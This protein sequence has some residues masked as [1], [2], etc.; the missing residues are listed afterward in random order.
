MLKTLISILPAAVG[1]DGG[2]HRSRRGRS[3]RQYRPAHE[4]MGKWIW[5]AG[6]EEP[7]N[8]YLYARKSFELKAKPTS[9]I[10]KA[11]ADTRYKLYVNGEYVGKGPARGTSGVAYYDPY[12]ITDLLDKGKNVIA[13]LVHHIGE[14]TSFA[15]E[16]KAGLICKVEIDTGEEQQTV[17]TD[18]TWLVHRADDWTGLGDRVGE[19]LGFQEAYDAAGSIDDWK[20]I[21]CREKNWEN[22]V[23]VGNAPSMP[24][25]ILVE[26]GVPLLEEEKV[27]PKT[28]VG[29]YNSPER[30]KDTP[31]QDLP[32]AM[33][34]SELVAL[35][36]GNVKNPDVLISESGESHI[37]TP[38]GDRGVV[39]ILDFGEEVF[40]NVELGI[41]GTGSG[42]IDL[43]YG[44]ILEDGRVKPNRGEMK[45]ADKVILK[46]GKLA[47][48]SFEP[49]AFRYLQIEFRRCS[50]SV[51]LEYVRVNQTTYPIQQTGS[52]ECN[53]S[54]L[55]D[56]WRAGMRTTH[57]CMQDTFI[58]DPRHDRSMYWSDARLESRAAYYAFDDTQLLAHGLK[59]VAAS[60]KAD[61][62]ISGAIP[63][64]SEVIPDFALYW[65]FSILDYFAFSEDIGLLRDL[66]PNVK[67]LLG[68]FERFRG[69]DELLACVPGD[70]YIDMADVDKRGTVTSLNCLYY[71]ALRVASV[72]A[73]VLQHE[74]E[75]TDYIE[76]ANRLKIAINK[77]LFSPKRGLYADSMV[78]GKLLDKFSS[79][80][81]VLAAL[82]DI[83]D[84]YQKS[85]IIRQVL[86]G[87]LP[88][89]ITP[90]FTSHL[91]ELLYSADRYM[92]A[93]YILRKKWG[94]MVKAGSANVWEMFDQNGGLCHGWSTGPAR[95]LIAE[96]VGIKP[97]LGA[98]RFSI[99]PQ[100]CDLK[101]AKG[102][103]N[104]K[105]GPLTVEW[106]A[107]Q[108]VFAM[109]VNVPQ[110]LK[111]DV[112]PPG[113]QYTKIT[114][115]GKA[116]ASRLV[117]ISGGNH[118]IKVTAQ[119]PP[120]QISM[121]EML[122]T[123]TVQIVELL[124]ELSPKMRRSLGLTSI[125]SRRSGTREGGR[126]KRGR[127]VEAEVEP[128]VE[129]L[130]AP[131]IDATVGEGEIMP[132][133][134]EGELAAV[135]ETAAKPRRRR[136]RRGRRSRSSETGQPIEATDATVEQEAPEIEIAQPEEAQPAVA[137]EA[138]KSRRRRSHRGGRRRS[139]TATTEAGEVTSVEVTTEAVVAAISVEEP[140]ATDETPQPKAAKRSRGRGRR[141]SGAGRQGSTEEQAPQPEL[142][143]EPVVEH[144]P[145]A[146]VEAAVEEA[147]KKKRRSYTRRPRRKPDQAGG[148]S[149]E[150]QPQD[151]ASP[152]EG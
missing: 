19:R 28:L 107:T 30:S 40:G 4:D 130:P 82:F 56:I 113:P 52:F 109:E 91:L 148:T 46:K 125:R 136:V 94:A 81:N 38:R 98:H 35:T 16:G 116:Q 141:R 151:Q 105:A 14:R 54:I 120:K 104:T 9:A 60:Q 128:K 119:R 37:K 144:L 47:W 69:E 76:S 93:L 62:A 31:V 117:T 7:R 67:K 103:I 123:S 152:T 12:D 137:E 139:K 143:A 11:S 149:G 122:K 27:Y 58:T 150:N 147:P 121:E 129:L 124:D 70:L 13:F 71:Q 145:E 59:Q 5:I 134:T 126:G 36:A 63:A 115:D 17:E 77:Y 79:Q 61:G 65:I 68:W 97:V 43:G 112:Y 10:I 135:G 146:P 39:M 83:A 3:R 92:D 78:D 2:G 111:V 127:S 108:R 132:E 50:K 20:A 100:P 45:Y 29:L 142:M 6:S 51:P 96:Y 95:D 138:Q 131:E 49:R 34:D 106:H 88:E 74:E 99:A 26:R 87:S 57:L 23:V 1:A 8:Y 75:A 72:M 21:K 33:A 22:A 84:H 15:P 41:G 32:D 118:Q 102:S 48:Q 101:W 24:W 90:F 18:E 64:N 85:A 114:A 73:S 89:I 42:S 110:G 25:G 133:A 55:N 66:Y 80:T 53:D 140:V 86:G 44:E